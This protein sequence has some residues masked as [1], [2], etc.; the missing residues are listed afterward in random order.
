MKRRAVT[1]PVLSYGQ[2]AFLNAMTVS[3]FFADLHHPY[4]PLRMFSTILNV[5]C[6]YSTLRLM[7]RNGQPLTL[8]VGKENPDRISA[9]PEKREPAAFP[10]EPNQ[11]FVCGN[12]DPHRFEVFGEAAHATCLEWLGDWPM[13]SWRICCRDRADNHGFRTDG[14]IAYRA[15]HYLVDLGSLPGTATRQ[16]IID[17][18]NSNTT[19]RRR[20]DRG[21]VAELEMPNGRTIRYDIPASGTPIDSETAK[22]FYNEE[23][24]T[25]DERMMALYRKRILKENE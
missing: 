4:W 19:L 10:P 18:C 13:P 7:T 8:T 5:W 17:H 21:L 2:L 16:Q 1:V 25:V 15:G 14:Y 12:Y 24:S 23:G 22:A 20:L 3:S 9:A 6:V 11:C